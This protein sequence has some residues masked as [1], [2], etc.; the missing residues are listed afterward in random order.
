MN[1]LK[2]SH[3]LKKING[4]FVAI[5]HTETWI[6]KKINIDI[7]ND[8]I[9]NISTTSNEYSTPGGIKPSLSKYEIFQIL[10]I[11][12]TDKM[13]SKKEIQLVHCGLEAYL[14]LKFNKRNILEKLELGMDL[15]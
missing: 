12:L 2:E 5:Y 9:L 4:K 6:Y 10:K 13:K 11:P 7:T 1:Q 15:P 14:V 3:G 8:H